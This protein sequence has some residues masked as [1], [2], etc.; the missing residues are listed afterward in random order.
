MNKFDR[1][2]DLHKILA[3]RRTASS[4]NCATRLVRPSASTARAG[5]FAPPHAAPTMWS[6][7]SAGC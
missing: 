4:P 5:V 6:I 7:H 1:L 2:Y 3:G